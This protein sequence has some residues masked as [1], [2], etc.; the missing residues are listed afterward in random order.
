MPASLPGEPNRIAQVTPANAAEDKRLGAVA[1][2]PGSARG[3]AIGGSLVGVG[4]LVALLPGIVGL[5][6]VGLPWLMPAVSLAG[7]A[8]V[9]AGAVVSALN[10]G[11]VDVAGLVA[12]LRG[13][14][15]P[16]TSKDDP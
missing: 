6:A 8:I 3:A 5:S 4:L 13:S 9:V 1:R 15:P 12:T 11:Q 7:V 14:Q 10:G 16:P 2:A